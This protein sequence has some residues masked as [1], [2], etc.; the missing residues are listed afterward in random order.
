MTKLDISM[1]YYTFHLDNESS[2]LCVIV[3]PFGKYHY[4]VLPMELTCSPDW[5]Q[6]AME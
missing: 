6:G 5:A 4:K 2:W 1:Q 3:T